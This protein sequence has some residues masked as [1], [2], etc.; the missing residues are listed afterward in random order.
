M[1][2]LYAVIRHE[3]QIVMEFNGFASVINFC[4]FRVKSALH[5]AALG[6]ATV[7]TAL[8]ATQIQSQ[9]NNR[10]G[11]STERHIIPYSSEDVITA[12]TSLLKE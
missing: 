2:Q 7:G 12:I 1:V 10:S 11:L 8:R 6:T 9:P 5:R 3:K 4:L